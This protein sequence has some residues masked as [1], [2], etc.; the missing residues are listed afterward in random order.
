MTNTIDNLITHPL[1]DRMRSCQ[2]KMMNPNINFDDFEYMCRRLELAFNGRDG[3]SDWDDLGSGIN[4]VVVGYKDYA[5]KLFNHGYH[6]SRDISVLG[7]LQHLQH[8]PRLFGVFHQHKEVKAIIMSRVHGYTVSSYRYK[9]RCRE[10]DNFISTRFN[11]VFKETVKEIMKSGFAPE[12]LHSGNV[13]IDKNTGYP[14]IIDVGDFVE[15]AYLPD[16]LDR[17]DFKRH[18][19]TYLT[20]EDVIQPMQIMIDEK[21]EAEAKGYV[22]RYKELMLGQLEFMGGNAGIGEMLH[23]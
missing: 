3:L 16:V 21:L 1:H 18:F 13:M 5:I 22:D 6:R 9:V 23:N 2:F 19:D 12:D 11:D 14:V 15:K 7:S 8:V 4:G 10:I 17:L 20:Y